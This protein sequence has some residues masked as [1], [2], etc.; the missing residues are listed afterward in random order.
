MMKA[1]K[2]SKQLRQI[3]KQGNNKEIQNLFIDIVR[4][5]REEFT[6]DNIPTIATFLF[7]YIYDAILSEHPDSKESLKTVLINEL[8]GPEVSKM[9]Q[10]T[11]MPGPVRLKLINTY[12]LYFKK[13]DDSR[14]LYEWS[15]GEKN[16]FTNIS[17]H[18]YTSMTGAFCLGSTLEEATIR[19]QQYVNDMH[20]QSK[21][22][23]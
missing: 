18:H 15:N 23:G 2:I 9:Q 12:K 22:E 1:S 11:K 6:E 21:I 13:F 19:L 8:E 10:S 5:H 20:D 4:A 7:E 14:T 3:I 16:Y 17:E